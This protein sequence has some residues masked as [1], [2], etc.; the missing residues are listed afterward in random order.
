MRGANDI[1]LPTTVRQSPRRAKARK[2]L[3][4]VAWTGLVLVICAGLYSL[5]GHER[6]RRPESQLRRTSLRTGSDEPPGEG[7]PEP[8]LP[9]FCFVERIWWMIWT[10]HSS[11]ASFGHVIRPLTW[12]LRPHRVIAEPISKISWLARIRMPYWIRAVFFVLALCWTKVA[13]LHDA[14]TMQA[15]LALQSSSAQ[16]CLHLAGFEYWQ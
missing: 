16:P 2:R 11:R 4:I 6:I 1:L 15:K 10:N 14:R 8:C 5:I 7:S 9:C 13:M 3:T 12:P